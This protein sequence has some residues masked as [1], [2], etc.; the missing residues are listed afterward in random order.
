MERLKKPIVG[1][2]GL[3]VRFTIEQYDQAI[4]DLQDAKKQLV[5]DG[6]FC[7]ICTD[8]GHMAFECGHN[9][10]VA[11]VLCHRIAE[12]SEKLHKT[13]HYLAGHHFAF[14]VQLG[15]RSVVAPKQEA[16]A[17]EPCE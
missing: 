5:A 6:N 2:R 8:S 1:K 7:A 13:L 12:D 14:G 10:L 11:M 3:K 9:P 4:A 15:P 17:D 16:A